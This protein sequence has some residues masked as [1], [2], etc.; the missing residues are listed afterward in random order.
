MC[1]QRPSSPP[2]STSSNHAP[3]IR[4]PSTQQHAPTT[5]SG[6]REAQTIA[7]S[8]D[9]VRSF[10]GADPVLRSSGSH[11][12][13]LGTDTDDD[14]I[15]GRTHGS[16][17]G[18]SKPV[19]ETTALLKKTFEFV[20]GHPHAGPCDHGTFSPQVE[21]QTGSV[22]S[23]VGGSASPNG[24]GSEGETNKSMF[25]SFLENVG[26]KNGHGGKKKT[27]TTNWVAERHGITNTITLYVLPTRFFIRNCTQ[28]D[29]ALADL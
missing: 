15:D 11:P 29:L 7:T 2:A 26:M 3:S 23:G 16:S 21:S 9:D 18:G 14:S 20:T 22:R 13:H 1:S 17:G 6:L 25:S 12:T 5:P 24:E 19:T 8:P 28:F 4:S 27:S 10:D